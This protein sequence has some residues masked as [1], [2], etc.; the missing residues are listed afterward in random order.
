MT[1]CETPRFEGERFLGSCFFSVQVFM[2]TE[3][4]LELQAG[5]GSK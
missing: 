5:H 3:A 4:K 2:R 1:V